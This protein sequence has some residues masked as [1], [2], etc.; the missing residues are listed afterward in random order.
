MQE[1]IVIMSL[2]VEHTLKLMFLDFR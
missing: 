1:E 2:V